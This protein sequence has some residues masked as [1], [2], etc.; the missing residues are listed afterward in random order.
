MYRRKKRLKRKL[1]VA[2]SNAPSN[3]GSR[4]TSDV[5]D[6]DISFQS[7]DSDMSDGEKEIR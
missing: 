3:E 5:E 6:S 2:D 1:E 4:A 7:D